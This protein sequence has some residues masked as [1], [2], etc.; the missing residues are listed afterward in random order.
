M[1]VPCLQW[2]YAMMASVVDVSVDT[3]LKRSLGLGELHDVGDSQIYR[4]Q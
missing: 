1:F 3:L 4:S 2:A